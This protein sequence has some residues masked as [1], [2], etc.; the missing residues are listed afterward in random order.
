MFYITTN[1]VIDDTDFLIINGVSHGD[2]RA[3][4][5]AVGFVVQDAMATILSRSMRE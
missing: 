4:Q 3:G 2:L 1:A 5:S